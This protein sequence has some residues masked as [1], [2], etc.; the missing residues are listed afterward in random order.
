MKQLIVNADDFALTK[1]VSD[2]IIKAHQNGIVTSTSMLANSPHFKEGVS[3]LKTVP[4][5]GVGVHLNLSWGKPILPYSSVTSLV[6]SNGNFYR[7]PHLLPSTVNLDEIKKELEAQINKSID[8]G[9][10]ISHLDSHHHLHTTRLEFFQLFLELASLYKLP[11]R[12]LENT[13]RELLHNCNVPTPDNFIGSFFGQQHIREEFLHSIITSIHLGI[14]ELMCHPGIPDEFLVNE[15]SYIEERQMELDLLTK[16]IVK[17]WLTNQSIR[18]VNY[19]IFSVKS[20]KE[21]LQNG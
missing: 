15:S 13:K 1:R 5:I 19:K 9:I 17:Q 20:T 3:L 12:T 14:S 8:S 11:L 6:D 4:S 10:Q 21:G 16:P 2:G 18:L 7:K